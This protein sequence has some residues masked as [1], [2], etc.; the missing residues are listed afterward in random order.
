MHGV[1][2]ERTPSESERTPKGAPELGAKPGKPKASAK[3]PHD[4]KHAQ[5]EKRPHR[6]RSPG[7]LDIPDHFIQSLEA[8]EQWTAYLAPHGFLQPLLEELQQ[9]YWSEFTPTSTPTPPRTPPPPHQTVVFDHLVLLKGPPRRVAWAQNVWPDIKLLS[10]SSVSDAA[11]QL[12]TLN[13]N[14]AHLPLAIPSRGDLIAQSLP[15][16][17]AK[18]IQFAKHPRL[19]SLGSFTLLDSDTILAAPSCS[20]PFPHGQPRFVEDHTNPPSRAYL[21]LWEF[22]TTIDTIPGSTQRCLDLGAS[23]GGWSWVLAGLGCDVVSVDKADL[24]PQLTALPNV[25]VRR[26]SAFGLDPLSVG[27]VHWLFS[28]IICYPERLLGLVQR[29][30]ESGLVQNFVCSLKLQGATDH[31][32]IRKFAA[33]PGSNLVHLAVNRHELTWFLISKDK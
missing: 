31:N 29:W 20:S 5:A 16:L 1:G 9:P 13:R 3:R 15:H 12:R 21:K 7:R 11:R 22:F 10:V 6:P 18:P 23:P 25:S 19:P 28:D 33:I 27:P 2:L 14:W 8:N 30:M 17:S 4:G 32:T 26:E 24:A